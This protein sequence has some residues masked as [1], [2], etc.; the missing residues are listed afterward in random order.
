MASL[1]R[2]R[3]LTI[4]AGSAAIAVLTRPAAARS[5]TLVQWRGAALGAEA[6]LLLPREDAGPAIDLCLAEVERLEGIL[7]LYRPDSALSTLNRTG[8]LVAPPPEL[9][10]VL[11]AAL[12]LAGQTNG[13]FDP[14]VQPL[15]SEGK[16]ALPRVGWRD[17]AVDNQRIHFSRPGM[18]VTLNGIAQGYVTDRVADLLRRRGHDHVLVNLGETRGLGSR[19][20][21]R[22]WRIA[23]DATS[24]AH[25]LNDGALATSEPA[26]GAIVDP[27]TGDPARVWSRVTV[28]CPTAM[29]ADG[30]S[31]A[32]C[33]LSEEEGAMAL[34]T[35]GA[36][37]A[38][39]TDRTG[40]EHDWTAL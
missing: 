40:G 10:T 17:L 5:P 12:A 19:P 11:S 33:L 18:A 29:A 38:R 13:A 39:F 24:P 25:P 30:L 7:S 27:R 3:F 15:W 1:S 28:A 21:G 37:W 16:A 14:T 23:P 2:R 35:M 9:V 32:L 31:T 8:L 34:R 20:D 6:S 26:T 36:T 4:A 22:P